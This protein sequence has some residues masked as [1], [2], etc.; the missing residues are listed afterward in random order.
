MF[1]KSLFRTFGADTQQINSSVMIAHPLYKGQYR[2]VVFRND[3]QVGEF[4]INCQA[5]ATET[6][7]DVDLSSFEKEPQEKCGCG[8]QYQV[9]P[10]GY[11]F[12]FSA[13]GADGFSV[14][15]FAEGQ[16]EAYNTRQLRRGDIVVS[17]LMR[18][19]KYEITGANSK[20]M[21][22]IE[23]PEDS[24][25]YQQQLSRAI[26]L[27]LSEKGFSNKEVKAVPGQG[28]VITLE[29]DSNIL[30]KLIRATPHKEPES[31]PRWTK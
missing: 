17:M 18:P 13:T 21:L 15:L 28:L 16:K 23:E 25:D 19:G 24:S 20:S 26:T 27:A 4:S 30:V 9:K 7:V 8:H 22:T 11:V 6:Q 2:G 10:D 5:E 29:T 1:N 3:Q 12:F 14:E 31:A